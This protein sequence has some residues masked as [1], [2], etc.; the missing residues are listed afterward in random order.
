M[1]IC[2]YS[3]SYYA[4][5]NIPYNSRGRSQ[6]P[7]TALVLPGYHTMVQRS[8]SWNRNKSRGLVSKSN[9]VSPRSMVAM[10][11]ERAS[12]Y[13]N[14]KDWEKSKPLPSIVK[15]QDLVLDEE[16]TRIFIKGENNGH[17]KK[18]DSNDISKGRDSYTGSVE[19]EKNASA[20]VADDKVVAHIGVEES[21]STLEN[22]AT[23]A[24]AAAAI[25]AAIKAEDRYKKQVSR[26]NV[27]FRFINR[28]LVSCKN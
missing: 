27:V 21:I 8:M 23:T 5:T 3:N 26:Y 6:G 18:A 22:N 17:F 2:S 15:P 13:T 16:A 11:P 1:I 20:F 14:D 7:R 24:A 12:N 10:E 9:D 28:L 25:A 19:L 4:S